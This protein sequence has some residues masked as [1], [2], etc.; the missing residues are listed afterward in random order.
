MSGA[1]ETLQLGHNRTTMSSA[2]F[3]ESP[4]H[5]DVGDV[6]ANKAEANPAGFVPSPKRSISQG[7]VHANGY[8]VPAS[9]PVAAVLRSVLERARSAHAGAPP[10]RLVLTHPEGWSPRE[11]GVLLEAAS[12]LGLDRSRITTVSEPRAAAQ[13]YT[14]ARTLEPGTRIAVF[15]FGGGTLDVA[16]LAAEATGGFTVVAARGDNGL[17]GKNLD[18]FLRRWLDEQ[19]ENRDPDLLAFLRTSAPLEARM[20]LDESIRRAKE[21]LSEAPSATITVAGPDG[22]ERFLITREEFEELV[23]PELT[24]AVDLTSRTL[25]DAGVT[26]PG[27]LEALYL[28][29]GSSRIP[30]VHERLRELGPLTTLDDPKTVVARGALAAAARGDDDVAGPSGDPG[31]P[32]TRPLTRP[33]PL[34]GA[35]H[36]SDASRATDAPADDA[37]AGAPRRRGLVIGAVAAVVLLAG[38]LTAYA[39]LGGNDS[40]TGT[41]TAESG[42]ENQEGRGGDDTSGADGSGGGQSASAPPATKESVIA[43]LPTPLAAAIDPEE[44]SISGETEH[45]GLRLQCHFIEDAPLLDGI[46]SPHFQSLIVSTDVTEARTKVVRIRQQLGFDRD[47]EVNEVVENTSRTAA[48]TVTG[49]DVADLFTIDYANQSTGVMVWFDDLLGQD[50]ATTFLSRAGLIN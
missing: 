47:K 11:V 16:V 6:A 23:D 38:G 45:G 8:D 20:A 49:P 44:C 34:P 10:S 41:P 30:L 24:R 50:A 13:Y 36:P 7:V 3:V 9:V 15:D 43:S 37:P 5:V 18:A 32:Q 40:G 2:V 29:G 12:G 17:G 14:G 22:P 35:G 19:I 26:G 42:Q 48:A 31:S 25:A 39:A 33:L 21:L 46:V 27:Q 4:D 28:T 1:V